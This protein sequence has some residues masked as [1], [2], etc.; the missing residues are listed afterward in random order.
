MRPS[1]YRRTVKALAAL[2]LANA[3]R[4]TCEER[5]HGKTGTEVCGRPVTHVVEMDDG[6]MPCCER[7]MTYYYGKRREITDAD[8]LDIMAAMAEQQGAR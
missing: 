1:E 8:R 5:T 7:C 2:A 6:N 3:P 4:L